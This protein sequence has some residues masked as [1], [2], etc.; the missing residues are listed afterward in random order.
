MLRP[1]GRFV[2]TFPGAV[3]ARAAIRG[4]GG[5]TR[6]R[7][8][9]AARARAYFGAH[10]RARFG[11]ARR[12]TSLHARSPARATGCGRCTAGANARRVGGARRLAASWRT[13]S[14]HIRPMPSSAPGIASTPVSRSVSFSPGIDAEVDDHPED[15]RAE[16][17]A[18]R[19][20]RRSRLEVVRQ[21]DG[22]VPE[23]EAHHG[24][25][26]QRPS[27]RPPVTLVARLSFLG[28][29]VAAVAGRRRRRRRR[30]RVAAAVGPRAGAAA[31]GR[32]AG[33]RRGGLARVGAGAVASSTPRS[34]TISWNSRRRDLLAGRGADARRRCAP[35]AGR[36]SGRPASAVAYAGTI[37]ERLE[38]ARVAGAEAGLALLPVLE[39]RA[40]R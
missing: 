8:P 22:E 5:S 31:A 1:G 40:W 23:G 17:R 11:A 32:T 13:P 28:V 26:E 27:A 6:R 39:H 24:P 35:W 34:L 21:E 19:T 10:G 12:A 18:D 33:A 36:R 25:D 3:Y 29:A 9:R 2:C 7:R 4:C 37:A 20:R 38:D 16:Q 14:H 15:D 30:R